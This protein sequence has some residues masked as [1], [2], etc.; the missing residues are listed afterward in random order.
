MRLTARMFT[1]ALVAVTGLAFFT[2][3]AGGEEADENT[4]AR[5]PGFQTIGENRILN[6]FRRNKIPLNRP[7]RPSPGST[8]T[9]NVATANNSGSPG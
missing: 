3:F 4:P 9:G 7:K 1:V 8:R 5:I 6:I 2:L